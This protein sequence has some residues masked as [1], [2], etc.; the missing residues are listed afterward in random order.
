MASG[1]G[2]LTAS[3][4]V[5]LFD[6]AFLL[7]IPRMI[8]IPPVFAA[9][10]AALL[11]CAGDAMAQVPT[12]TAFTASDLF[13]EPDTLVQFDYTVAG[14]NTVTFSPNFSGTPTP[15]ATGQI[16]ERV[17]ARTVYTLTAT[18][19]SGAVSST[20]T[21]EVVQPLG[22]TSAGWTV[23]LYKSASTQINNLTQAQ[24]LMDGTITRGNV[25]VGGVAK[26]TP[27]T[28]TDQ[29]RIN[30]ADV[31]SAGVFSGDTWPTASFGTA[32]IDD[33]VLR[34]T[35]VLVVASTGE[36]TFN[37]N[38]DDGGR[39][40]IDLNNDGDFN[41][42]G[43][44]IISDDAL[45][46][47]TTS[48]ADKVLNAGT[49]PIEYIYFERG[50][51]ATGEVF[52]TN[53]NAQNTLLEFTSTPPAISF[54]DLRIIEFMANNNS[55]ISDSQGDREDWIEIYN[56]T[57]A[58]V[59]LAGYYL[60]DDPAIPNK[61]AFPTTTPHVL[62]AGEYFLVFASSK[63]TTFPGDEYHTNFKLDP[64]GEYLALIKNDGQGG[65]VVLQ[66]FAPTF[67]PQRADV[68]YG[69]YDSEH[70][71][72]FFIVPTPR[73]RNAGG[74]EGYVT[75]ETHLT[76]TQGGAIA[77][78]ER[79]FFSAPLLATLTKDDPNAT[80]RYTLDGSTPSPTRGV[81]YTSPIGISST[82]VLRSAA[83]RRGYISSAIDTHTCIFVNDVITQNTA[84]ATGKGWPTA[85]VNGQVFDYGM[86]PAV[87]TGNE[88]ATR[89]ALQA[90]PTISIVT[91]LDNLVHPQKGI[92][93]NPSGRGKAFE[94][95]ASIELLNNDGTGAGQFQYNCGLRI[96][97][98]FSRATSNPKHA[99]HFYFRGEYDGDLRFPMFGAEGAAQFKQLDLQCP[100]N[101]SWSFSPQNATYTYINPS[102]VSTT[103]RL[104]YNTFVREPV[105]RDL[106]GAMGQPYGRTRYY[107]CYV[108]GQYW[109]L[110]MTEERTEAS[111]GQTYLGGDNANYDT[112]K[113]AANASGYNTE[114]T[115]GSFAQGTSAAPG[116]AWAKLWWRTNEMRTT[117][118]LTEVQRRT[119]YFELMGLDPTGVPYN[120]PV[121]HPVVLDA[122]N[123]IDYMLVTWACGSFDAPLSTFLNG[124]SNNWFG[125]RDRLGSR[126]FNYFPHDFEHGMG[127]DLQTTG[128]WGNSQ[129]NN[130]RSTD[131]TGPWGANGAGNTNL[132]FKGQGMYNQLT[133]YLKSNPEFFH[134][135]LASCLEYRVRFQDR[136][137][138]HLARPGGALTDANV[139]AAVDARASIVRTAII[140]ESARWGDAKGVSSVDFLPAGWE[141]SITQIKGWVTQ[142]S[143]AEYLASI[144]TQANPSGTPGIGRAARLITQLRAYR[145]ELFVNTDTTN[146]LLPLYSVLDAPILSNLGGVVSSGT[147]V[148]ITNS[149]G[150]GATGT[151]Y[152]SLDGTDPRVL[153]GGVNPSPSV[154]TGATPATVT[155]TSTGRVIARVYDS[156]TTSWSGVNFADFIVGIPAT[157]ANL[158]ITE[159]NYHPMA[160]APGT[161]TA[162]DS[163]TF[164]FIELQNVS[165]T[166]IDLTNVRFTN[167]IAYSFPTGRLLAAGE[168]IVVAHDLAAFQSR[169]PDAIYPGLSGKTVGPWTGALDNGGE[170]LMLV[171]TFGTTIAAFTYS[172]SIPW[173]SGPD[174]DG[175]T[176]V[177]TNK[178]PLTSLITN[179]DNWFAHGRTH[180]NPGGTDIGGYAAWATANGASQSGAGD[181]DLDG[182]PDVV[183]YLL[184]SNVRANSETDL[185]KTAFQQ[186][187]VNG[188]ADN[189]LTLAYTRAAGTGD[190]SVI[191]ETTTDPAAGNWKPDAVVVSRTY[192]VSGTETY[193]YRAPTLLTAQP[194][195]FMRLR[196]PLP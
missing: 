133:T 112:I 93:V 192:N 52:Y 69:L 14:A 152:W 82:T 47:S 56:G 49:Y 30:Y 131:R 179:G 105:S 188:V 102:G 161:P 191:C 134:E 6:A 99:W 50:G 67:P 2:C 72:G 96:R 44:V 29:P 10:V 193:L 36:Y 89:A 94:R 141:A 177:F 135:N 114:A 7:A 5:A 78:Y 160:G 176:L 154:Q 21:V 81:D 75:G 9:I 32:A 97:G 183:E 71:T 185:P 28:I 64:D 46:G 57:G 17:T 79:G 108:N 59:S 24:Q 127:T 123:L 130:I 184:G 172:D 76:L 168:R 100:E 13:V 156:A 73:G 15:A 43:E 88:A 107:H 101:Y 66:Q 151:L 86:S 149:N 121:N 61:W 143:N 104:R 150:G 173:P 194:N 37:I 8:R 195:Q 136:A 68:S 1:T 42:P 122:D 146:T 63:N 83:V 31:A 159:I 124:A 55:G 148:V 190:L 132:N 186:F 91:D 65:F 163:E 33:F 23:T 58:P 162:G 41:D 167:G 53:D 118:G 4:K 111:F 98:G 125:V 138:R 139:Q 165:G 34:A 12:I 92:Y 145:D 54:P 85:A 169:Y 158:V 113:S 80:L 155:L 166:T 171:D 140:A 20:L 48:T 117:P 180:G 90:I 106:F 27:I 109:G 137:F 95:P 38:N 115:D 119:I 126:G 189:Y 3:L 25:T 170:A 110:Y 178:N 77:P 39:L 84:T 116:S 182:V 181:D 129:Q 18:N 144:P 175:A 45:H 22:V 40:R 147:N 35:A 164:E 74:Y 87:V 60:T 153:G 103:L 51:G 120:D 187:T 196:V 26:P 128:T 70:Y 19:A 11:A 174:G 157:N 142:G 16:F 62:G